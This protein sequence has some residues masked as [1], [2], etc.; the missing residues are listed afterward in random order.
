MLYEKKMLILSGDGKGV[1]LIEKCATGVRFTMRTF[2]L[3]Q[4]HGA[5]KVGIVTRS[6]VFVRDLPNVDNPAATFSI[7]VGDISSL[8]FAVFDK[9]LRLYG[10]NTKRMWES[11]L[12]DLLI[13]HDRPAP[14]T[15]ARPVPPALPPIAPT[16]QTLPMPDGTGIPQSRLAIYGDEALAEND[17]YTPLEIGER[18]KTVDNFLETPRILDGLAPQIMPR[19]QTESDNSVSEIA[20]ERKSEQAEIHS[21]YAEPEP[22]PVLDDIPVE[23]DENEIIENTEQKTE[24]EHETASERGADQTV[25]AHAEPEKT[26]ESSAEVNNEIDLP[27]K[28]AA[29]VATAVNV[30]REQEMPWAMTARY[31]KSRSVR[32]PKENKPRVKPVTASEQVRKLRDCAFFERA[33]TDIETIFNTA[34]KDGTLKELLPDIDWVKV[35]FD[36]RVISVGRGGNAFLCYAVAGAYEKTPPLGEEAQW[37]P[38]DK[39]VP[40]GNG[41]WLIFQNLATGDIIKN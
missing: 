36:G 32:M 18:M 10:T 27:E 23:L 40:T 7:D 19:S 31:L 38:R 39:N 9:D 11:N 17:F 35:E 12:M 37:L 21:V 20:P 29:A 4:I 13:K 25:F 26:V 6:S 8:H 3:P 34:D 1:V 14:E 28:E 15:S 24:L 16:P 33:R 41:Y 30:S 2:D 22:E 5:L